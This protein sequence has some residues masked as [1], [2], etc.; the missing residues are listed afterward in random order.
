MKKL[1]AILLIASVFSSTAIPAAG[2]SSCAGNESAKVHLKSWD[3]PVQKVRN[4]VLFRA[5]M[6]ID[7]DGAPNAYGPRGKGLDSIANAKRGD[8]FVGVITGPDGTPIV[9]KRGPYK[10]FYVSPTS[11]HAAGGRE[12]NPATYVDARRIPYIA[13]PRGLAEQFSVT[14]GDLAVVVNQKNGR[15]AFAIYADSGPADKIGE[16]S[17]ALASALRVNSDPRHG[18]IQEEEITYLLFPKSGLGQGKLRTARDIRHSA[19]KLFRQ[20]GGA[21]RLKACLREE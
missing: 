7:A 3:F 4:A 13:L 5:G 1:T 9:Q 18:G 10:G 11:L 6:Q 8:R 16:G 20:W 2:Q 17:I 19:S 12:S 21:G 15:A 14:L